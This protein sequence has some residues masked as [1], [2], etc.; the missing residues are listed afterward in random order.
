[1]LNLEKAH[2]TAE[3]LAAV[4]R[5]CCSDQ[6]AKHMYLHM[7]QVHE[8]AGDD[9]SVGNT[10]D[11]V[12][13]HYKASKKVWLARMEWLM[14]KGDTAA[15]KSTLERSLLSLARRKHVPTIVKFAQ[16]EYRHGS[17]ERA[18]TVLDGVL[19]HHPKRLDLW[20]IYLDM[21]TR[22]GAGTAPADVRRLFERA[23]SLKLS[24]KKMKYVFKRWLTWEQANGDSAAVAHVKD[25]AREYVQLKTGVDAA[26]VDTPASRGDTA[27]AGGRVTHSDDEPGFSSSDSGDSSDDD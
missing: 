17:L 15:A 19:A 4:F 5:R 8:R 22:K 7:A 26:A 2:G 3:S 23:A 9:D 6:N 20:S 11:A 1:L 27:R 18:R 16:L 25:R 10:F 24:S 13:R 21:E 12:C 14:R